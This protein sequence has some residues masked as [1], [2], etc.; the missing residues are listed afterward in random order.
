MTRGALQCE[1]AVWN[2]QT[3]K[4]TEVLKGQFTPK[5]THPQA[6]QDIVDFFLQQNSKE[7]F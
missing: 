4:Q 1:P 7:D 6:I 3:N 2:K 5:F